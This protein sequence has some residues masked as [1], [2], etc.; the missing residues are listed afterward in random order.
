MLS[1]TLDDVWKH[2]LLTKPQVFWWSR[3]VF[4]VL[5][6]DEMVF[7]LL[8]LILTDDMLSDADIINRYDIKLL[9][10]SMCLQPTG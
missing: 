2:W 3:Q 5:Q 4:V 1:Q 10:S 7:V 6:W 8:Y 9:C